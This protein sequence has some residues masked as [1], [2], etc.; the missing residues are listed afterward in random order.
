MRKTI[1]TIMVSFSLLF[2]NI[3]FAYDGYDNVNSYLPEKKKFYNLIKKIRVKKSLR[4]DFN[5]EDYYPEGLRSHEMNE[6]MFQELNLERELIEGFVE[7]LIIEE[8][9]KRKGY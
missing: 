3:T 4:G 1:L 2:A 8:E 5:I 9:S 6:A 7:D